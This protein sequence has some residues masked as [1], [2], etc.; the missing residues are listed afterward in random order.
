MINPFLTLVLGPVLLFQAVWVRRRTP[1]LPEPP[2]ERSGSRGDGP[3]L[4]LAVIGDSAAAGVGAAHQDEALTGQIVNALSTRYQVEWRLHAVTGATTRST[5]QTLQQIK[6]TRYDVVV[7]SLGVNDVT[8]GLGLRSWRR[9]QRELRALMR[10]TFST[11][12][13]LMSGLPPIDKFPALPQPLRWY[14]GKRADR[15]NADLQKEIQN[16]TGTVFLNL[17]FSQDIDAMASDGFHPGPA[18]YARWAKAAAE[19]ILETGTRLT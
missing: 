4:K 17:R 12:L 2:G 11:R 14:L 1:V 5:I 16:E 19:M 9:H 15:F 10:E 18:V 3:C 8:S 7:T 13:I 6:A